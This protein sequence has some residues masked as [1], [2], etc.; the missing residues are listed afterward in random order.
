VVEAVAGAKI[1]ALLTGTV[2]SYEQVSGQFTHSDQLPS[3]G[4]AVAAVLD[5]AVHDV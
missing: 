4:E 3:L 1:G 2:T 5:Q